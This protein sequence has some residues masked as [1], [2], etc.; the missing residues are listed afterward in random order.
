MTKFSICLVSVARKDW[1]MKTLALLILFAG[2][3]AFVS[4]Y[5]E[6]EDYEYDLDEMEDD[7]VYS[8][9]LDEDHDQG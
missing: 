2:L 5:E 4:A 1:N 8:N 3:C 7:K 9:C 6:S